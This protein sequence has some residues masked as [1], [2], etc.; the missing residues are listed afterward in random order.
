MTVRNA[1]I[2]VTAITASLAMLGAMAACGNK[3]EAAVNADGKPIVSVLV[4]KNTNQAKLADQQWA[5]D[6][7]ADCDCDI[8]WKEVTDD[9]WGQQKNP[10][11]ASKKIADVSI[12]AFTPTDTAQY[13]HL[14]EDLS[15]NMDKLSNVE[16]FFK[17]KP[18]AQKLTT[19]PD[20][21]MYVIAS[22]RGKAYSGSGQHLMIN[23]SWLDK[24]GLEVPTTWDEFE[25]VLKAFK[26]Q[27]PNG[28][29]QADE[30][31][32]NIR[33]LDTG[34]FGWYSP[35]LLMNSTGIVTGF[36]KGPTQ[37]GYYV[38]DGKVASYLISDEFKSVIKYY[39]K[40]ISEGLIPADWSTKDADPYY[41][42]Q[43]SGN[44]GAIFGW[45]LADF[46]DYADQYESIPVPSAPGVSAEDTVW[47]LST[48]EYENNKL[49]ISASAPNKEAAYK[50]ANLLYSEKYSVQQFGGSFG[51]TV[52]DD[53][54][55]TYTFDAKK[56]DQLT[57]D[58]QFPGLADRLAGWIPDEVTIKGDDYADDIKKV[59]DPLEEQRSHAD[60]V[61]DYIPDY[62]TPSAD[63]N[64]TLSNLNTPIMNYVI[65]QI[66]T[67]MSDGG[68]DDGWDAY[69]QQVKSLGVDQGVE[70]WQKWYDEYT[71]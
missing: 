66:A 49:A 43:V 57:N 30:I 13:S 25:T 58:N 39:N 65:P 37:Q 21:H 34:G 62:V 63:D 51:D 70:I 20:G 15:Q 14:F 9:Q 1:A 60:P 3:K 44:T 12:R 54:D 23:K 27:D 38:K 69:V 10:T 52:T 24:L 56:I 22:S 40:L 41:A 48:N 32:F 19:D 71:K 36:N 26:T 8:E 7:E 59:N 53:G 42:E 4:V 29:G 46:G 33:K 55:H 47:D 28:N 61:K 45:S 31:P 11:L 64:T 67:W 5:K 68:V 35:M 17:E 16:A 18:E 2:K 6:L 50:V